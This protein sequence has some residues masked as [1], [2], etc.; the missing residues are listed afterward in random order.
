MRDQIPILCLGEEIVWIIGQ[1]AEQK[2]L[3]KPKQEDVLY[4][5]V[6]YLGKD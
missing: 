6:E 1:R 2:F 3:A 5:K 4:I